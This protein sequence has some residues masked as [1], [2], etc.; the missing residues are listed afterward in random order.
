VVCVYANILAVVWDLNNSQE[1]M[2]TQFLT[3]SS[4]QSKIESMAFSMD[5]RTIWMASSDD[6]IISWCPPTSGMGFRHLEHTGGSLSRKSKSFMD[7]RNIISQNGVYAASVRSFERLVAVWKINTGKHMHNMGSRVTCIAFSPDGYHLCIAANGDCVEL[8]EVGTGS[9]VF[10][11]SR[12]DAYICAI[13]LSADLR[14]ASLSEEGSIW[15]SES[16]ST[17]HKSTFLGR[18]ESYCTTHLSMTADG[19]SCLFTSNTDVT[20]WSST[21]QPSL[22][23]EVMNPKGFPRA[24]LSADGTR[25]AIIS[26]MKLA[27]I[28]V[29]SHTT[30]HTWIFK[31]NVVEYTYLAMSASGNTIAV[32][33][34]T[35]LHGTAVYVALHDSLEFWRMPSLQDSPYRCPLAVSV[36][37]KYLACGNLV[38]YNSVEVWDISARNL[39][40]VISTSVRGLAFAPDDTFLVVSIHDTTVE[41][42]QSRQFSCRPRFRSD[43]FGSWTVGLVGAE[44]MQKTRSEFFPEVWR[45]PPNF[46]P[47]FLCGAGPAHGIIQS[48]R[49]A[50]FSQCSY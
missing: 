24:V 30:V 7:T 46:G 39:I 49:T 36:S 2:F 35:K 29:S 45:V 41:D 50:A 25:I 48:A 6:E 47:K 13:A 1:A 22:I 37:G 8:F 10:A 33:A 12:H 26:T 18:S 27:L 21:G 34:T 11:A 20:L 32:A 44:R 40:A 9:Q 43:Y 31:D 38:E 14:I 4:S 23:G 5:S 16:T 17:I 3:L 15:I 28:N 19:L 42:N